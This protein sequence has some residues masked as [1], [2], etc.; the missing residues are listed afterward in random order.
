MDVRPIQ[1]PKERQAFF[2]FPWRLY[3]NDP[4]W[5]PPLLSFRRELLDK[6][7][8]PAWEYVEGESFGAWRGDQLVGT[9][10]ALINHRH[11]EFHGERVGWFAHFE[12]YD[13]PEAANA[14]LHTAG[15]WV[16]ERGYPLI[17][18]P[19]FTTHEECGL[20]IENFSRPVIL[21]PY[22][23][24]YYQ[25]LIESAGFVKAMDIVSMYIDRDLMAEHHTLERFEKIVARQMQRS[26]I[27][28]RPVNTRKLK[29][30]FALFKDLYNAAWS[31][32]WGFVPMTPKE[33]DALVANLGAFFDPKLAF[34]AEVGG[35]PAGFILSIPNFNE[36]LHK[37]YPRPGHPEFWTLLK[38]LWYWKIK[39][40]IRGVRN[41]LMGVR[42]EY[43]HRGVDLALLY[44]LAKAVLPTQYQYVDSGWILE[45]NE[46]VKISLQLGN[47]IYKRHRFYQKALD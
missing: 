13:D 47:K 29:Q 41:P 6:S 3:K 27:T 31:K 34:F 39:R 1:T 37:A 44:T 46:L 38:A 43:R 9:I 12:C 30:E 36:V 20:L 18:G 40:V 35:E 16:A 32:N 33:L 4:H 28:I 42:E 17:R 11:N 21:M 23:P 19:Q 2:E 26:H 14:L 5:V 25:Q 22:N 45:T 7:K 8:H 24:P 15:R 10:M